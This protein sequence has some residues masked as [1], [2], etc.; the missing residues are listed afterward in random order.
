MERM[1]FT[2]SCLSTLQF[3]SEITRDCRTQR[4]EGSPE[5]QIIQWLHSEHNW[6]IFLVLI[7]IYIL[8][9]ESHKTGQVHR[10]E[11]KAKQFCRAELHDSALAWSSPQ[12]WRISINMCSVLLNALQAG[13]LPRR[14]LFEDLETSPEIYGIPGMQE[15]QQNT[16]CYSANVWV[17]TTTKSACF[18]SKPSNVWTV[19]FLKD[20]MLSTCHNQRR[21]DGLANHSDSWC[22]DLK[23]QSSAGL[24][25]GSF[26]ERFH[27][28]RLHF[29]CSWHSP[30]LAR[31]SIK[32][33]EIGH[34][35]FC[36]PDI[37]KT[38]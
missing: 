23:I 28:Q 8:L 18:E 10:T 36:G 5:S 25:R 4:E 37:L 7:I 14:Q 1:A 24:G 38:N 22:L 31:V 11:I 27:L 21:K 35:K 29:I 9:L 3:A 26:P 15:S 32:C 2:S 20:S 17:Q 16:T 12:A 19:R 30:H 33:C 6:K 13:L 34:L